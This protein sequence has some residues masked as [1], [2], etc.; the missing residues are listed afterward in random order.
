MTELKPC[1]HCGGDMTEIVLNETYNYVVRCND[2][3][4]SGP[5]A[6]ERHDAC[7]F[8]G[9]RSAQGQPLSAWQTLPH[10]SAQNK[11]ERAKMEQQLKG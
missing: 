2:C 7:T 11:P 6:A 8:W 10:P 3:Y 9:I 1:P 5:P 4:A